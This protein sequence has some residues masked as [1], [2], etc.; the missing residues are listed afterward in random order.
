LEASFSKK[1][2]YL[3]TQSY[4]EGCPLHPAYPAGHA[5]IA[6]ACVT[7]LKAFFKESTVIQNPV[8]VSED[9]L[10]LELYRGPD[11]EVGGEFNKLA[12]NIAMGRNFAGLHWRSDATEGVKFGEAIAINRLAEIK[13]CSNEPFAGFSL[14]KFDGSTVVI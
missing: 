11:L 1:A 12:F 5:V 2:T 14:T 7:I 3:L 9:G 8:V 13:R 10:S 4:P 6:G